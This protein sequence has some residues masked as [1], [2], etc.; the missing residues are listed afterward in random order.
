MSH[1]TLPLLQY[2][3]SA[4]NLPVAITDDSPMVTNKKDTGRSTLSSPTICTQFKAQLGSLMKKIQATKPHYIRCIK[5]N[6][7]NKPDNLNRIRTTEQLRYGGVLEAVRVARSGF[8]VRLSHEDFFS[9]YRP[10][11][12]PF[13]QI[14]AK[15]PRVIPSSGYSK[16]ETIKSC[17][18]LL[19]S[20][21]D[22]GTPKLTGSEKTFIKMKRKISK[23]EFWRGKGG[24][25]PTNSIQLGKTKVFFRKQAHDLFEGRRSRAI[26]VAARSIQAGIRGFMARAWFRKALKSISRLQIAIRYFLFHRR[27]IKKRRLH[28]AL[29]MQTAFRCHLHSQRF[30]RFKSALVSVQKC[31]RG[32]VARRLVQELLRIKYATKLQALMKRL[33][34]RYRYRCYVRAIIA[35]QCRLRVKISKRIL[36]EEK[37]AAR[38]VGNLRQSNEQLKLEIEK[39]RAAAAQETSRA[40]LAQHVEQEA[41]LKETFAKAEDELASLR[42]ELEEER[43]TRREVERKLAASEAMVLAEIR[44][45]TQ[46][47]D[48]LSEREEDQK[49][50]AA[51]KRSL[52]EQLSLLQKQIRD[53]KSVSGNVREVIKEVIIETPSKA[54]ADSS[55]SRAGISEEKLAEIL[56]GYVPVNEHER[57]IKALKEEAEILR[58]TISGNA[59]AQQELIKQIQRRK[60]VLIVEPSETGYARNDRLPTPRGAIKEKSELHVTIEPSTANAPVS[61][62]KNAPAEVGLT[63]LKHIQ[64]PTLEKRASSKEYNLASALEPKDAELI[65]QMSLTREPVSPEKRRP[66]SLRFMKSKSVNAEQFMKNLKT[67]EG[68]ALLKQEMDMTRESKTPE[69]DPSADLGFRPSPHPDHQVPQKKGIQPAEEAPTTPQQLDEQAK[70]HRKTFDQNLETFK[71]R[72]VE[73]FRVIVYSPGSP[74][75]EC[76][77]QLEKPALLQ[78]TPPPRGFSLFARKPSYIPPISVYDMNEISSGLSK[79]AMRTFTELSS[80]DNNTFITLIFSVR[81]STSS[82]EYS[83]KFIVVKL[84]DSVDRNALLSGLRSLMNEVQLKMNTTPAASV[85]NTPLS[86]ASFSPATPG[87]AAN[88]NEDVNEL[89]ANYEM[90]MVQLFILSND[91]NEREEEIIKLRER[92]ETLLQHMLS[93]E[94]MYE[95]DAIVRM[96]LGKRLEQVLMDKE[97]IKDELEQCKVFYVFCIEYEFFLNFL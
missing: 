45:R 11:A 40:K 10:I 85:G 72:L 9:R 7:L 41:K 49:V 30:S 25:V 12:N 93:K 96:Q 75:T 6:D 79:D 83:S 53:V 60:S 86:K 84:F 44:Q 19:E 43:K 36:R 27:F 34:A 2:I 5:P 92:E 90:L 37:I 31:Y 23:V 22:D 48:A 52:E 62:A 81:N 80:N 18:A 46:L 61:P 94:K 89:R 38:D 15:L 13:N 64:R 8:P 78:F 66:Q 1:S 65:R 17:T 95:Q 69:A 54:S 51:E 14:V 59:V 58:K 56:S 29:K 3:F 73:G 57:K 67:H 20:M 77:L 76:S 55:T 47:E 42:A 4:A 74:P 97:E 21:W 32:S 88:H 35:L 26:I 39:L 68:I 87:S 16:A 28:A 50:F 63:D 33:R 82:D 91:L 71:T 24:N 70:L